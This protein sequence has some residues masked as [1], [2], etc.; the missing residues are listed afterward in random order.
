MNWSTEKF[1]FNI[2]IHI[3]I[4][5]KKLKISCKLW[6]P[7][8]FCI[9]LPIMYLPTPPPLWVEYDTRSICKWSTSGFNWE[10]F[11]YTCNLSKVLPSLP[12]YFPIACIKGCLYIY[13]YIYIYICVC[14][15]VCVCVCARAYLRVCVRTRVCGGDE[16]VLKIRCKLCIPNSFCIKSLPIIYFTQPHRH[17]RRVYCDI[18]SLFKWNTS[19]LNSDFSSS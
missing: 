8:S 15:C 9:R 14:V 3:Y 19:G 7:N 5:W 1:I 18:K 4:L 10:V 16:K 17:S 11:S 2:Y 13:I 12:N 6:N